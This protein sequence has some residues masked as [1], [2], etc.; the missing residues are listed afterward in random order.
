MARYTGPVCKLC[1][2]EGMKLNLKG[3]R[4]TTIKCS[5]DRRG[6]APG[7]HGQNRRFKQSNFGIQLREKQKIRRSYGLMEKQFRNTY[8]KASAEKGVT[9]EQLLVHLES[10]LDTIVYRLGLA[11]SLSSAR[12][13]VNHGHFR[14]NGRKVDIPS[15]LM[16]PGDKVQVRENSRKLDIIHQAMQRIRDDSSVPYLSLDKAKMEGEYIAF[17]KR[18]EIPVVAREQYVVEL[19]SR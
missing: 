10:R 7:Q 1:R 5:F 2:R 17:P 19:Y 18:E 11:P 4:C 8:K 15:Y 13:L 9:G 6:Y 14:V 3:E 16:K 12:Q